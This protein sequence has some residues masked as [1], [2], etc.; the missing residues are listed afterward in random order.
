MSVFP[1]S[2]DPASPFRL[3]RFAYSSYRSY[4]AYQVRVTTTNQ[5]K[6]K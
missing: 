6:G 2:A 5:P 3:P 1:R 4:P